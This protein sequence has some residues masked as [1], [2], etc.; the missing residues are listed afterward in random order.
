MTWT[1]GCWEEEGREEEEM[2]KWRESERGSGGAN[3]K[4]KGKDNSL[5]KA[6]G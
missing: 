2:R 4:G 5:L 6:P 3:E 1:G